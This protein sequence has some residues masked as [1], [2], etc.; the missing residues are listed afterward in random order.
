VGGRREL[1]VVEQRNLE[2]CI[3]TAIQ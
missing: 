1:G 2:G 3:S